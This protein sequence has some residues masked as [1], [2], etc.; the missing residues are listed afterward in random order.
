MRIL[1]DGQTLHTPE[2][3]R[4]IGSYTLHMLEQMVER[5]AGHDFFVSVCREVD[6]EEIP[7]ALRSGC[8]F[9]RVAVEGKEKGVRE[10]NALHELQYTQGI[11]EIIARERIDVYWNPNPLMTNVFFPGRVKGAANIITVHDL[12]PLVFP[13]AYLDTLSREVF[14]DYIRRLADL[15]YFDRIVAVSHSTAR[16]IERFLAIPAE[17]TFVIHE[18]VDEG[19]FKTA[20]ADYT[21]EIKL[22]YGLPDRFIFYLGGANFRKN[23]ANLVRALSRLVKDYGSDLHLVLGSFYD[24]SSREGLKAVAEEAGVSG[25]V[26]FTG[27]IPEGDKLGFYE[28][29]TLFVFPSLYEG[30]GLPV[31]EA[32]AAGTPVAASRNSSIPEVL[33]DSG[34]YFNPEDPGDIA[35]KVHGLIKDKGACE[36]LSAESRGAARKFSWSAAADAM[37]ELME[38]VSSERPVGQRAAH[39]GV[40]RARTPRIAWFSPLNPQHSGI[41]DYSEELLLHLKGRAE[42]DL[43]VDGITPSNPEIADNFRHY[44]FRDF[45]RLNSELPYDCAVYHMGNNTCHE[46][47]YSTLKRHPGITVL[48]D[49]NIHPFV[50]EVT[51]KKGSP[52]AYLEEIRQC[53]GVAGEFLC[54]RLKKEKFDIDVNRFPLND[55]VVEASRAV[56]V[57][58]EWIKDRLSG[59]ADKISVFPLGTNPAP[60]LGEEDIMAERKR[61]GI[62][63]DA[64]MLAC[65]GDI[66]STKRIDRVIKAFSVFRLFSEKASL[67]LVGKCYPEM[68]EVVFKLTERYGLERAVHLTG[69]VTLEEFKSYMRASD[70]VINL[71][72]PTM[73]ETSASLLRALSY[74]KPVMVSNVNQ[75]R[76]FP[77]E[78]TLKVDVGDREQDIILAHL[79]RLKGPT[80]REEIGGR[81]RKYIKEKHSFDIVSKRLLNLITNIQ[82]EESK[83]DKSTI[84]FNF[85]VPSVGN[86][87]LEGDRHDRSVVQPIINDGSY[88]DDLIN[89]LKN[90]LK[91]GDVFLDLGGNIGVISV[92]ASR[93]VGSSGRVIAVEAGKTN[94][95][96]LENNMQ[97]VGLDNHT[98]LN[99]GVWDCE[100]TM[101]FSYVPEVAACSFFSTTGVQEGRVEEVRCTTVDNL[102][103]ELNLERLD[104]VKMDIEGAEFKALCGMEETIARFRPYIVFE[105][106]I[107]TLKRFF[108]TDP[109]EIWDFFEKRRYSLFSL[110]DGGA[111]RI[112]SLD[113]F[114][115]SKEGQKAW[116]EILARPSG[117]K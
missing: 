108:N 7:E 23:T 5:G 14:E 42:I 87:V 28:L 2:L 18:G 67:F 21:P 109:K 99:C 72:W 54:E 91:E 83:M 47:I 46:Y 51:Y 56:V 74:G 62:A 77:G 49:Y 12:I 117:K 95:S 71:R 101:K 113:D 107:G 75:F 98:L 89:Y 115:P 33:G 32:M 66:V 58:S 29:S 94:F 15:R 85:N 53:Y 34:V 114:L 27:T 22:R 13:E 64:L 69:R 36:K 4:G 79:M 52:E 35:E 104:L 3:K 39:A 88:E 84:T 11:A 110:G 38:R 116:T 111:E 9:L 19:F 6:T 97:R 102:A 50:R 73:G 70:V 96:H 105:L 81:A 24:K 90:T 103:A 55:R 41:A 31:L 80:C 43:F 44:D 48:H 78:C 37:L 76:E 30:F 65:F 82:F 100:T 16:D 106:N 10:T 59:C 8:T 1:V 61:L 40:T 60:E 57:H 112:E 20:P 63:P 26:V 86:F 68:E 45:E 25:R 92:V 93:L 17:K